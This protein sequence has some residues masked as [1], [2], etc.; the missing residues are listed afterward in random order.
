MSNKSILQSNN[1]ALSAN[2]LD[3]QSLIDQA[4]ALPDAGG[5]ELPE[6]TNEGTASD[7]LSGKQLIDGDG[8]VVTGTIQTKTASDLTVSGSTITVPPGYYASGAIQSVN[9]AQ[10]A[11]TTMSTT[12]DDTNDKI[13]ITASNNQ[14]AGY[15]TA[16]N[17]TATKVISLS[18]S[19]ATVTASDGT[20]KVSKTVSTATQATPNISVD[21]NGKITANSTQAAGYVQAGTK[22]ATKQLTT[23]AAKTITPTKSSQTAVASGVYTT[24]AVTVGAIPSEYI[25]T[26]DATASADEI[27]SGETAY[28]NGSKITGSF[29]L[30]EELSEQDLL[31]AQIQTAVDNLPEANGGADTS[32]ATA[33]ADKIFLNE[34]AY[35]DGEKITGSF[36]IDSELSAQDDLLTQLRNA[37]TGK[38]A[39]SGS[40][41][42]V[43]LN[44][45]KSGTYEASS[46]IPLDTEIQFKDVITEQ[47]LVELYNQLEAFDNALIDGSISGS[48]DYVGD[49]IQDAG[50]WI[51]G[52]SIGNIIVGVLSDWNWS[53]YL[54]YGSFAI[55]TTDVP[56]VTYSVETGWIN[57]LTGETVPA[58]VFTDRGEKL[59]NFVGSKLGN[60]LNMPSAYNP[61]TVTSS[62][63]YE[64]Y[65]LNINFYSAPYW[66]NVYTTVLQD[67]VLVP[68]VNYCDSHEDKKIT[69]ENALIGMPV[70]ISDKDFFDEIYT[71]QNI[72]VEEFTIGE[73][74]STTHLICIKRDNLS[75]NIAEIGIWPK[76]I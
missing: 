40:G 43:P 70:F 71:S 45:S 67:G 10:R 69:I 56:D 66:H 15:V 52:Y 18:A 44:V 23:Q 17:K 51:E 58:P 13:T 30:E 1:E 16:S 49:S 37:M 75:S 47:Q 12:V 35:V 36:T 46:Y 62:G 55:E 39:G 21:A 61:V 6:L 11:N 4:N 9:I 14:E 38:A 19:G 73:S 25:T 32:D 8:N 68:Y 42:I 27:M 29:T 5:V 63:E 64:T 34:T 60:I 41:Q 76:E 53:D 74:Y 50:N 48:N 65:T 22:S 31:I 33:T 24:G 7:L 57:A 20:N 72:E 2:N 3:L 59:L 54:P 26:T 28:V